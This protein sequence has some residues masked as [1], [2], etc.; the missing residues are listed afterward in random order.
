MAINLTILKEAALTINLDKHRK[1]EDNVIPMSWQCSK[2]S[3]SATLVSTYLKK[4]YFVA[5]NK[6]HIL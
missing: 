4:I 6:K 2:I 1:E 5:T 3:A